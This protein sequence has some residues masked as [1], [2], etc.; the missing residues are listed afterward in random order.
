MLGKTCKEPRH[1]RIEDDDARYISHGGVVVISQGC[2]KFRYL[3]LCVCDITNVALVVV[4]HGCLHLTYY[5]IVLGERI[6]NFADLPLDDVV[7][8]L[9]TCCV[10][11]I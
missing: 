7:K 3:T 2:A 11:L 8:L 5:H 6:N 4:G 9:L 1:L 10:N